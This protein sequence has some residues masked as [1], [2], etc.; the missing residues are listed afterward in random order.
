V[1]NVDPRQLPALE[2]I[3]TTRAIR[4]YAPRPVED[5]LL[6]EVLFAATRAPTGRNRQPARFVVLAGTPQARRAR[7]LVAANAQRMWQEA[8]R[9]EYDGDAH[10]AADRRLARTMDEHVRRL[11]CAPV[12]VLACLIRWRPPSPDEGASIYPACQ[13]LLLAARAVGLGGVLTRWHRGIEADLAQILDIPQHVAIHATI[14]LGYPAGRHGLVRRRPLRDVVFEGRWGR[15]AP[16]AV[17]P[18]WTV[19]GGLV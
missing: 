2:V 8:L 12:L 13:N 9:D 3:A 4:R 6:A 10:T 15:P 17:D 7:E 19:H 18:A 1:T 14:P 16:W 5:A 11:G